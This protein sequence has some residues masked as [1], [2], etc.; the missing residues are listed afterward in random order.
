MQKGKEINSMWYRLLSTYKITLPDWRADFPVRWKLFLFILSPWCVGCGDRATAAQSTEKGHSPRMSRANS[1]VSLIASWRCRN[2]PGKTRSFFCYFFRL[3]KPDKVQLSANKKVQSGIV[4]RNCSFGVHGQGCPCS[5]MSKLLCLLFLLLF[6]SCTGLRSV[7]SEN[8]LLTGHTFDIIADKEIP[9]YRDVET[10]L[11]KV[12]KPVPNKQFLWMRPGPAIYNSID[13]VKKEKG[14]KNWLKNKVGSPPVLL[15]SFS[16]E[17]VANVMENRLYHNGHFWGKVDYTVTQKKRTASVQYQVMPGP[18]YRIDTVASPN[19]TSLLEESISRSLHNTSLKKDDIYNLQSVIRERGRIE[20]ALKDTGFYYFDQNFLLFKAD[21]S[22]GNH[23]VA[24]Q[25]KLKPDIPAEAYQQKRLG[26]VYVFD[27]ISPG[28]DYHPDT[29]LQDGYHYV[30]NRHRFRPDI[31]L[32][33]LY[34][35]TGEVYSRNHQYKSIKR[36]MNLGVHQYVNITYIDDSLSNALNAYVYMTPQKKNAVSA[37]LNAVVR[38]TSYAGPGVRLSYQD[39]NLFGGAE[40]LTMNLEG[41]FETQIGVDSINTTYQVGLDAGI[42]FPR[43][44]PIKFKK[45]G[46]DYIPRTNVRGGFTF[47]HRVELFALNSFFVNYGYS[48]QRSGN[49]YHQL[50]FADISFNKVGQETDLFL[51]YLENNPSV[52]Q[53]FEDQFILGSSYTFTLDRITKPVPGKKHFYFQGDIGL[54]GNLPFF[55]Q[56]AAKK[57]KPSEENP[58][59]LLGLPYAQFVRLTAEV[60]RHFEFARHTLATRLKLGY[61]IPW[62]NSA[63]LPYVRQFFTGGTNSIRA[64]ASHTVGPGSYRLP[65]ENQGIDQTG[66]INIEGNIEYRL[67]FSKYL[68]GALFL[69][70]GN[71]WLK[72]KDDERQGANFEFYRFWKEFAIGSGFGLR[73]D[74][75]V[76]VFRLDIAWPLHDPSLPEGERW[77]IDDINI[78]NAKWR[79]NNLLWNIAIGYP[80]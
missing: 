2:K 9:T 60:R 16:P 28:N 26:E 46:E 3:F 25:L 1:G 44:F 52:R 8:P 58:Y 73:F 48:W 68:K 17:N 65:E 24:L 78:F 34:L 23:N 37:E 72:K 32:D 5:T 15:Q 79:K 18:Y 35:K 55:I 11:N 14:V 49:I 22:I 19:G 30:S 36:L 62:G 38:T 50:N 6:S 31:V 70:A 10:E 71:I 57:D 45:F 20:A 63:A 67:G 7:S 61:G 66:D 77:V 54:S 56:S 64:F 13:T 21:S 42:A 12:L 76:L 80:F 51:D 41:S 59:R 47:F 33:Q 40:L 53:S 75:N 27:D 4:L 74:F 43:L 69:D 39:R 29:V